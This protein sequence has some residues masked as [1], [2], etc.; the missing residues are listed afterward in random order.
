LLKFFLEIGIVGGRQGSTTEGRSRGGNDFGAQ[1]LFWNL[2]F[3]GRAIALAWFSKAKAS[4]T[5]PLGS[6]A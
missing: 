2:I 3:G 5:K 1:D 6:Q 4:A